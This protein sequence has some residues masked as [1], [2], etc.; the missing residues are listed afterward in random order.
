MPERVKKLEGQVGNVIFDLEKIS[1]SLAKLDKM[2]CDL[3]KV[4]EVLCK[5]VDTEGSPCV[6]KASVDG[7]TSYVS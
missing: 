7:G 5:L 1:G 6:A 3:A 4:A 2:G